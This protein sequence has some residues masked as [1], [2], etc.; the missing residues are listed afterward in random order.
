MCPCSLAVSSTS[1]ACEELS[2]SRAY[3]VKQGDSPV[4]QV[5]KIAARP[6]CSLCVTIERLADVVVSC[7]VEVVK[8]VGRRR[9]AC[10]E[11]PCACH[12][13]L[14]VFPPWT[15]DSETSHNQSTDQ[16]ST[17]YEACVTHSK[18]L[19]SSA[20][21]ALSSSCIARIV[22]QWQGRKTLIESVDQPLFFIT[23]SQFLLLATPPAI[24][25]AFQD[26]SNLFQLP[27]SFSISISAPKAVSCATRKIL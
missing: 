10:G 13:Q 16:A 2:A 8:S 25:I 1:T 17:V 11:G 22:A 3:M 7:E 26:I 12:P 20:N 14:Q 4:S 21:D 6:R 19:G 5:C 18:D 27:V 9:L 23:A 15:N 24:D